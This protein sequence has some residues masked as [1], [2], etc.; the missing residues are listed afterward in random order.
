MSSLHWPIG[1]PWGHALDYWL[2]WQ[3]PV[4]VGSTTAV[5]VVQGGVRRPAEK[6]VESKPVNGFHQFLPPDSLLEFPLEFLV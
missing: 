5:Q 6:S 3:D 1:K 2:K 4:H